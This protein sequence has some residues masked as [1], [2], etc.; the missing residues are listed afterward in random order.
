MS[1]IPR[2]DLQSCPRQR[3]QFPSTGIEPKV[4]EGSFTGNSR[5]IL[6]P[7]SGPTQSERDL[8]F[9][10]QICSRKI[11]NRERSGGQIP[12]WGRYVVIR[13]RWDDHRGGPLSNGVDS[14]GMEHV[15]GGKEVHKFTNRGKVASHISI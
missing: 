12:G 6:D 2:D 7:D 15:A 3:C 13:S 11:F 1:F 9:T 8:L 5:T 4:V 14:P 10:Y